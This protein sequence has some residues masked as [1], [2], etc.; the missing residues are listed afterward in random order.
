MTVCSLDDLGALA[1]DSSSGCGEGEMAASIPNGMLC[2]TG[3][4]PGSTAA[5]VTCDDGYEPNGT[6]TM[7]VCLPSEKWSGVLQ[8]CIESK[9]VQT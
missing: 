7:L 5:N 6:A 9:G 1:S 2:Y 3:L 4:T 8:E